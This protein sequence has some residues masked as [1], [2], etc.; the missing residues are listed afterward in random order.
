MSIFSEI[1]DAKNLKTYSV[2]LLQT[3]VY[4]ALKSNTEVLLKPYKISSIEWAY[5]G[6]VSESKDGI[7]SGELAELLGVEAP[8]VTS[9]SAKF[10]KRKL[11]EYKKDPMD[12]RVR[13][14]VITADGL[15]LIKEVEPMLRNES[16]KWLKDLSIREVLMYI[17][18]LKKIADQD[19]AK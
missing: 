6:M 19:E 12:N 13:S 8:F 2:G 14:I 4:R 1:I 9:L 3:K 17:K 11:I 7:R 16:K 15:A 18:V 5:L 10:L